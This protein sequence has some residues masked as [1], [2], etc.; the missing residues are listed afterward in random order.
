MKYRAEL[1][2]LRAIAVIPVILFHA[3]F[4]YF[5]GGFIGVDIFFVISGYLITTIVISEIE[6]DTFSLINFYERRARRILPALFLVVFVCLI[7]SWFWLRPSDMKDFSKSLIAIPYFLSNILFWLESGYWGTTNALKPLLHTWTLAIEAQYYL[8]FPVYLILMWRFYKRWIFSSLILI[9]LISF[10]IS[11]WGAYNFPT[12]NF[13]LLPTRWWELAMGASIALLIFQQQATHSW[14]CQK[15]IVNE[16]LSWVGL[17]LIIYSIVAFDETIPFPS[18]FALMPTIGTGLIVLFS[19]SQT[20][21][22]RLLSAKYLVGIGLI[23]YSAYLWHQPIFAF[24]RHRSLTEPNNF[25]IITLAIL[26]FPLAYLSWKYV[27]QPFR[28][29]GRISKKAVFIFWLI[30]SITF[31]EVGV[32]GYVTDGFVSR[33]PEEAQPI[34]RLI[35]QTNLNP[36]EQ[37]NSLEQLAALDA[38]E[39]SS[40]IYLGQSLEPSN[41]SSGSN[42]N[43]QQ[44]HTSK[45]NQIPPTIYNYD[46]SI[47]CDGHLTW[48]SDCRTSDEP[49]ILIWGDSFAMHLVPGIMAANPNAKIIQMTMSVCGPLFDIAPIS[50][51]DYPPR[52]A[53]ECLAFTEKV[54]E[55]LQNNNTV[56]YAVL[57]SPIFQY[58]AEDKELILRSGVH[59]KTNANLVL[60][61]FEKTLAELEAMGITPVVFSPPPANGI[62][63]GRCLANAHWQGVELA[64][65]DFREDDMSQIR[66]NAYQLLESISSKKYRVIRLDKLMCDGATCKTHIGS[67]WMY[68][69]DGHLSNEGSAAL[70]KKYNFYQL[71]TN[72]SSEATSSNSN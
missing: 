65:C 27:E 53:K 29:R 38:I 48:S 36:I 21:V 5:S 2:G 55:W 26:V 37:L 44:N 56:K 57:S 25:I 34:G 24:A 71:I 15:N 59:V 69:D 4:Q 33:V 13:F 31:V 41:D 54:R 50:E 16:T 61:E 14:L 62:D 12:A 23:S 46:R 22:G 43:Q 67:I 1:D 18:F 30:G 52:W 42:N 3:G 45:P 39:Q 68:R 72:K 7:L 58:L 17:T 47:K 28:S 8:I 6:Q 19:S 70:G 40:L 63:L 60:E 9:T 20:W 10:M 32:A 66:I 49:E 64:K 35:G 51:P 11:Q